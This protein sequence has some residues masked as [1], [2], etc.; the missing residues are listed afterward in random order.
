[1]SRAT[2]SAVLALLLAGCAGSAP[3]PDWQANAHLALK[4]FEKQYLAGDTRGAEQEFAR[5]RAELSSTG[6][7][8]LVARAELTRC[9]AQVASLAFDDCPGFARLAADAGV[10]EKAYAAYLAGRWDVLDATQLPPQHRPVVSAGTLPTDPLSRLVAAG[11]LLRAGRITP[12]GIGS[13]IEAASAYG[14]RRPLLAWLGVDEKRAQ[15]AG[16]GEAAARLRRR[17]ETVTSG[18]R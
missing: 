5:A 15:A 17:I 6:R 9:A 11:V 12:A 14:W 18:G 13:A 1:M 16:E 8:E 4:N 2:P 3:P 10:E 7:P